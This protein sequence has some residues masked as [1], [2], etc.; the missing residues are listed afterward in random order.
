[1]AVT[2][3]LGTP[4]DATA[5]LSVY[6]RSNLARR[7]GNWPSRE[8][9]LGQIAANLRNPDGWFLIGEDESGA[10]AMAA[11]LPFRTDRGAGA[12]VPATAF[13]DLIYVLPDRWGQ[14]IGGR[15]L[16][17]VL[18]EAVRRGTQRVYL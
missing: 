14:G 11:V 1:M 6:E 12:V 4:A 13:L 2:V 9:R 7:H 15:M 3:R 18:G 16:D 5:A 17:G 10:V 8:A